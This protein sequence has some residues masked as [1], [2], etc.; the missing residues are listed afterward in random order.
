MSFSTRR[1]HD[2]RPCRSKWTGMIRP[3]GR[4]AS[5]TTNERK[6]QMIRKFKFLGL[7]LVAVFA[8]SAVGASAA[9]AA[10]LH[11][12]SAPVT[13]T[14][15][16]H[17]PNGFDVQFGLVN[18]TTADYNATTTG[19]TD[20]TI[21]LV[22]IFDGCTFAG[23]ATTVDT[24]GCHFL[25]HVTSATQG[26]VTVECEPGKEITVTGGNKCTVHVPSQDV[27]TVTLTN[28][29]AGATREITAHLGGITGITYSQTPG[30]AAVG[31]CTSLTTSAGKYTG[32]ATFTGETHPG[33]AHVGIFV[34]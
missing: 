28:T 7:A 6:H 21:T 23:V 15:T 32:T 24:N 31:K 18:C 22:P 25:L 9:S 2:Q 1:R 5:A 27:G 12:E 26:T 17:T 33:G 10:E 29:G 11:S 4:P 13:I 8:M 20:T 30:T 34:T 16:Q 14:G 19:T 3:A